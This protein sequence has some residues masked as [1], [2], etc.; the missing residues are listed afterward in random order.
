M[1][2]QTPQD[3]LA[4]LLHTEKLLN[5][6]AVSVRRRRQRHGCASRLS[7]GERMC[8]YSGAGGGDAGQLEERAA[9]QFAHEDDS[10]L[11]SRCMKGLFD[12]F[13]GVQIRGHVPRILFAHPEIR[14][15]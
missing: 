13:Q 12:V 2:H 5:A 14:H 9:R 3:E 7:L 6:K 11:M 15:G 10:L 4:T 8:L 1:V